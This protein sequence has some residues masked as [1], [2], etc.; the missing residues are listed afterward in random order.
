MV[1]HTSNC[2]GFCLDIM[3]YGPTNGTN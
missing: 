3:N 1:K 2:E